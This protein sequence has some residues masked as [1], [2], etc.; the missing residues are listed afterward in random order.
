MATRE[1]IEIDFNKAMELAGQLDDIAAYIE[2]EINSVLSGSLQEIAGNWKGSNAEKYIAQ[3]GI[4]E[5][6]LQ[7]DIAEYRQAAQDIRDTAKRY[8]E[9]EMAAISLIDM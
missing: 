1:S 3:G 8:Y 5:D 2:G 4:L 7:T 9:A 6:R